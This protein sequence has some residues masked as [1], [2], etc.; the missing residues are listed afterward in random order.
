MSKEKINEVVKNEEDEVI[1]SF[2]D[3]SEEEMDF[4]M[5]ETEEED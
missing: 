4:L 2:A 1:L 3:I 5:E